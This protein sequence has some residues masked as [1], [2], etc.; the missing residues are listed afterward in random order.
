MATRTTLR[1]ELKRRLGD[2]SNAIWADATLNGFIGTAISGVYPHFHLKA[3]GVTTAGAGPVQPLPA[4]ARNVYAVDC[5]LVGSTR[6]RAVL[7]WTEG[8]ANAVLPVSGIT[9]ATLV[10]SWTKGF[11][12]PADDVTTLDLVPEAEEYVLTKAH[13]AALDNLL[14]SRTHLEAARIFA[15]VREGVTENDIS[16]ELRSLRDNIGLIE[17]KAPPLPRI[18]RAGEQ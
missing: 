3:Q 10:W 9:G 16:A 1:D 7:E 14:S 5:Q 17:S 2:T 11:A 6:T 15:T 13:I 8:T 4:T 18:R 12:V